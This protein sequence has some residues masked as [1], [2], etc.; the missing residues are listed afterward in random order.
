MASLW[1][2]AIFIVVVLMLFV[3]WLIVSSCVGDSFRLRVSNI[4]INPRQ[5]LFDRNYLRTVTS[6]GQGT[7]NQIE[8]DDMLG[9]SPRTSEESERRR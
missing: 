4:S 1:P 7:W 9:E 8:M 6:S 3:A 2:L 5:A